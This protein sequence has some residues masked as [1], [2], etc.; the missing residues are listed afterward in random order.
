MFKEDVDPIR[1]ALK[2]NQM[3]RM[4]MTW[5]IP[6]KEA[7]VEYD[8]FTTPTD[9]VARQFL[10]QFKVAAIALGDHAKFTP[11]MYIYDGVKAGCQ[12][13]DGENECY[14]LCT[15]NGRYCATGESGFL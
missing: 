12:G 4:E 5:A 1:D 10:D 7:R 8:L 6:T 9:T 11:H 13:F 14:N 15:N 3:V 2:A